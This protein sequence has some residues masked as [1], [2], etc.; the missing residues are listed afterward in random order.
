MKTVKL[1]VRT[2]DE[3]FILIEIVGENI[4]YSSAV[5]T[6]IPQSIA[7]ATAGSGRSTLHP[8]LINGAKLLCRSYNTELVE[9]IDYYVAS[10]GSIENLEDAASEEDFY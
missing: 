5:E 8:A 10:L 6:D 2:I 9:P 4:T 1:L 7:N 3:G